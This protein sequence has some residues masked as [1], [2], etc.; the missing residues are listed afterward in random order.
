MFHTGQIAE[1]GT[2]EF[3]ENKSVRTVLEKGKVE[4]G[5]GVVRD[6]ELYHR[7]AGF[8]PSGSCAI[9]TK[10]IW[11]FTID[12]S[13]GTTGGA[14]STDFDMI[15]GRWEAMGVYERQIVGE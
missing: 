12:Y 6:V 11:G 1:Y 14:N 8:K 10:E 9:Y 15:K 13:D 7:S 2:P 3:Q 4:N 5:C